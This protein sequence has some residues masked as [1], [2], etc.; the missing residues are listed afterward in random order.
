MDEEGWR[1]DAI[2]EEEAD[3]LRRAAAI[4][5]SCTICIFQADTRPPTCLIQYPSRQPVKVVMSHGRKKTRIELPTATWQLTLG[6]DQLPRELQN[7]AGHRRNHIFVI[8]Q[9]HGHFMPCTALPAERVH[10][11]NSPQIL[12]DRGISFVEA[13]HESISGRT[14]KRGVLL[15]VQTRFLLFRIIAGL[16][17]SPTWLCRLESDA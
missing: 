5:S 14:R 13:A 1:D 16:K 7:P 9:M 11:G 2:A 3:L 12:Q 8:A 10:I 4:S 17:R 15:I 6:R